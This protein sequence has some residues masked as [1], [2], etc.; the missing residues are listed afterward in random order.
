MPYLYRPIF[1]LSCLVALLLPD[2]VFAQG[3]VHFPPLQASAAYQV[4]EQ[5]DGTYRVYGNH[6]N[7]NFNAQ[8]TLNYYHL[9]QQGVYL[10][11]GDSLQNTNTNDYWLWLPKVEQLITF[12]NLLPTQ[13]AVEVERFTPDSTL[14]YRK[15][16]EFSD[17][18]SIYFGNLLEL[19]NGDVFTFGLV[20]SFAAGYSP[21]VVCMRLNALGDSVWSEKIALF[22]GQDFAVEAFQSEIKELP[23]GDIVIVLMADA[24][25]VFLRLTSSGSVVYRE[26]YSTLQLAA[27]PAASIADNGSM[28]VTFN[29]AQAGALFLLSL[30]ANAQIQ[31]QKDLRA[32]F[33]AEVDVPGTYQIIVNAAGNVTFAGTMLV[34]GIDRQLMI[35]EF[36]QSN[37]N[38]LNVKQYSG[39]ANSAVRLLGSTLLADGNLAFCGT[40]EQKAIVIKTTANGSIFDGGLRGRVSIDLN[41]DCVADA[42]EPPITQW[43]IEAKSATKSYFTYTTDQGQYAFSNLDSAQYTV[44]IRHQNYV[45]QSCP[46]SVVVIGHDTLLHDIAVRSIFDCPVMK[47]DIAAPFIRYCAPN[48]FH[49]QYRNYGS[50]TA[51]QV[52]VELTLDSPL[53][54]AGASITP[55]NI[56]G[57]KLT[58]NLPNTRPSEGGAFTVTTLMDCA[59]TAPG[60]SVCVRGQIYPDS[61]CINNL[62]SWNGGMLEVTPSCQQDTVRFELKN[63][64]KNPTGDLE[65]IIIED[66][67]FLRTEPVN[68]NPGEVKIIAQYAEN[69]GTIRLTAEQVP[70][71]PLAVTPNIGVEACGNAGIFSTGYLTELPNQTGNPFTDVFCDEIIA[72]FDPNDKRALPVGYDPQHYIEQN[73]PIEYIIRFQNTGNDTAFRVVLIDTL[74]P[75]LDFS[76][77]LPGASSHQYR[78]SPSA[79]NVLVFTFDPIALP[80]STTNEPASHGFVQFW[81]NQQNNVPKGSRIENTARIYF[82]VNDPVVTNTT[83]HTVGDIVLSEDGSIPPYAMPKLELSPNPAKASC[84]VS[85][86]GL[87]NSHTRLELVDLFGRVLLEQQFSG[88]AILQT[89]HLPTGIYHLH[90]REKQTL[91]AG[92]KLVRID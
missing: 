61:I 17:A 2:C 91:L 72:S 32:S 64:G 42:S 85:Y 60:R 87:T 36:A 54:F 35:A 63:N 28:F 30:D 75:F 65:Y 66:H 14:V 34:D 49:I 22:P 44:R 50:D 21:E 38:L 82:D 92:A 74:S 8:A 84:L 71:H 89:E 57:Q 33:N 7:F 56:S 37:G 45:W 70:G 20:D 1:I 23:N 83:Y 73:T 67:I 12:R 29:D 76:T 25:P 62:G 48:T 5:N 80:D 43:L 11:I 6:N 51:T 16:F 59:S 46:D 88:Q 27:N 9:S 81:V 31:W 52:R 26:I 77:V 24:K 90:L 55:S 47:L 40:W 68:L 86:S 18:D 13:T 19:E 41:T 39:L 4:M 69:G 15:T 10:G 79:N 3:F 58:F 53:I 78:F